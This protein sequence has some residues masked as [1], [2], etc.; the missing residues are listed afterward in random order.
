M[1]AEL[2]FPAVLKKSKQ[3]LA[4]KNWPWNK[5]FLLFLFFSPHKD[6]FTAAFVVS[7]VIT[8]CIYMHTCRLKEWEMALKERGEEKEARWSCF[9]GSAL[10]VQT[11]WPNLESGGM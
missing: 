3:R 6:F 5:V 10:A 11:N 7:N 2:D 1:Q 4:F 9:A 8:Q